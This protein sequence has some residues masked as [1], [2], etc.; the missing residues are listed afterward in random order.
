MPRN[1]ATMLNLL[2]DNALSLE[3]IESSLLS[4]DFYMRSAAAKRLV[5]RTDRD[6]R[7]VLEH[8]LKAGDVPARAN[9]A[10]HLYGLSWFSAK[11]LLS[12]ALEDDDYR[13]REG[14]VYALC[15]LSTLDAYEFLIAHLQHEDHDAVLGAPAMEWGVYG[16]H[17]P[18]VVRV[19]AESMRAGNP[20]IRAKVTECLGTTSL[21]EAL[22][23][24]MRTMGG[25]PAMHVVY[26]AAQSYIEI[27]GLEV[28]DDFIELFRKLDDPARTT[29]I[30]RGFFHATN[31]R[32][33][34]LLEH[35]HVLDLIEVLDRLMHSPDENVRRQAIWC[36]VWIKH[37][38]VS[39]RVQSIYHVEQNADI[40]AHILNVAV[41]LMMDGSKSLLKSALQDPAE[42]VQQEAANLIANFSELPEPLE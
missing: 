12:Q 11:Q 23:L 35:K 15:Q 9:L 29:A 36:L 5:T 32:H 40:K 1:L 3:V 10:R 41:N 33:V 27:G 19:L 24:L 18:L 6:A 22:P 31:Y 37:P 13:V 8:V 16:R 26:N 17:D 7:L 20:E 28:V 2:P 4:K 34:P 25:D 21:S 14:A 30:L 42:R 39:R 38:D